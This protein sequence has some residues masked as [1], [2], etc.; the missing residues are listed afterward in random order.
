MRNWIATAAVAFALGFQAGPSTQVR[1]R[2][3]VSSSSQMRHYVSDEAK[4][5][6]DELITEKVTAGVAICIVS[7]AGTDFYLVGKTALKGGSKIKGNTVFQL[8]STTKAF[9]G[10]LLANEILRNKM[11]LDDSL[12]SYMPSGV[13]IPERNGRK[14]RLIDLVTHS[15]G[16]P[17]RPADYKILENAPYSFLQL[18]HYL[19]GIDLPWDIGSKYSYSSLGAALSGLAISCREHLPFRE[20]LRERVLNPLSMSSTDIILTEAMK[21]R[22][23]KGHDQRQEAAWLEIPEVFAPSGALNSTIEDLARFISAGLGFRKTSLKESFDLSKRM[24]RSFEFE[25]DMRLELAMFW[26]GD[27][28]G[29]QT[30]IGHSGDTFGFSAYIGFNEREKVG[31]AVLSNGKMGV[32]EIGFH[33]LSGGEHILTKK[34]ILRNYYEEE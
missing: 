5:I 14:I 32:N 21:K 8:G 30:F 28:I 25:D 29:D 22:V 16:L 24:L 27:K 13:K 9:T 34:N 10:V 4:I 18:F 7:E 15:S 33:I 6:I 2:D 17:T 12:E 1:G 31:V 19:P 3:S 11:S 20:V 26:E 23:S